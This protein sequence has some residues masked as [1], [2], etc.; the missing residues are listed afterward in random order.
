MVGTTKYAVVFNLG[1]CPTGTTAG[2]TCWASGTPINEALNR[3]VGMGKLPSDGKLHVEAGSY[4]DVIHINGSGSILAN[5]KGIVGVPSVEGAYTSSLSGSVTV[6]NVVSGFTLSGFN[7]DGFVTMYDNT[8]T[9]TLQDLYVHGDN[10]ILVFNHNGPIKLNQ[11]RAEG[12]DHHGADLSNTSSGSAG[13]EVKNSSFNY[14]TLA[15]GYDAGLQISSNGPV[16]IDGV[17]ASHNNG[18]GLDIFNASSLT[19]KNSVFSGNYADP[20]HGVWGYGMYIVLGDRNAVVTMENVLVNDNENDGI[21]LQT[22][23]KVTLK[24]VVAS[25]N[26]GNGAHLDN[27]VDDGTGICGSTYFSPVIVTDSYF[28][29]NTGGDGLEI[30]S[31]GAVTLTSIHAYNNG[32]D[33]VYVTIAYI[34]AAPARHRRRDHTQHPFAGYGRRQLLR[35]E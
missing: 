19:V 6:R 20:D 3:M 1:D 15:G 8:G 5:F 23:G 10:G 31:K 24:A 21:Y 9:I 18:D 12:N 16:T 29:N 28:E 7:I 11:V 32:D 17:S 4:P 22:M 2:V 13:V 27:C 34:T 35:L 26:G 14:N 30:R 33:G 25:Q